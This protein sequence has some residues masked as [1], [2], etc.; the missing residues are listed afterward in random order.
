MLSRVGAF[1][2]APEKTLLRAV[3]CRPAGAALRPA[4]TL[5]R[6]GA[7]VLRGAML[8]RAAML[9]RPAA[10]LMR[11]AML[12]RVPDSAMEGSPPSGSGA[13]TMSSSAA[14]GACSGSCRRWC[15]S[16]AYAPLRCLISSSCVPCS[17][18][19]PPCISSG[20]L[21]WNPAQ[22]SHPHRPS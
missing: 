1:A 13:S 4:A 14:A 12:R 22:S 7:M 6:P 20:Y 9:F 10:M 18:M 17:S 15:T 2:R 21:S 5:L 16:W 3:L 19:R 8:L 11:M